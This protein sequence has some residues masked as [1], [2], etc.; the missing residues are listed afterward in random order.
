MFPDLSFLRKTSSD[1]HSRALPTVL[2]VLD[3]FEPNGPFVSRLVLRNELASPLVS[4]T[5]QRDTIEL[6]GNAG[7]VTLGALPPAVDK[8]ALTWV[9]LRGYTVD[10][11]GL[12][13]PADSPDEV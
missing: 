10:Q 6:G 1:L 12:Q 9:G 11:G 4:I 3:T 8:D 13:A 2:E 5:L 7:I